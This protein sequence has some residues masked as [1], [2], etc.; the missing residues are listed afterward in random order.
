LEKPDSVA[1]SATDS[2]VAQRAAVLREEAGERP[3]VRG[4]SGRVV[5]RVVTGLADVEAVGAVELVMV[6]L[7]TA[8]ATTAALAVDVEV[9][10][11]AAAVAAPSAPFAGPAGAVVGIVDNVVG[12]VA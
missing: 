9:V 12:L 4:E 8:V 10:G 7:G 3:A 2:A 6:V 11:V 1:V 5:A